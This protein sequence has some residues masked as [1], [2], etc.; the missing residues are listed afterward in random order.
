MKP[1]IS[2]ILGCA[3]VLV[4][5]SPA[6]AYTIGTGF[7]AGCHEQI[8]ANAFDEILMEFEG[9]LVPLPDDGEWKRI[10]EFLADSAGTDVEGLS[11][12]SL[13]ILHSILVGVRAPDT[14]GHSVLNLDSARA[15]HTDPAPMGQYA[16][17]L[18]ASSD[19]FAMGDAVA[20][21]GTRAA[22]VAEF[23]EFRRRMSS[24]E[25]IIEDVEIYFDFYGIVEVDVF[26]PAFHIGR[27][28]H[29]VQ[30]SFAHSIRDEA[31]GFRS[32]VSVLNYADAVTGTLQE[33]RDGIAHS[34][35]MD[36]CD[37]RTAPVVAACTVATAAL[38][39]AA[40]SPDADD[41]LR[42]LLD[43]WF[44]LR[45]PCDESNNYCDNQDWVDLAR[46]EPTGPL[47]CR[48][49]WHGE[50]PTPWQDVLMRGVFILVLLRTWRRVQLRRRRS[51]KAPA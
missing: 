48:A 11:D 14:E 5:V 39:D 29:T 47:L 46:S 17:A 16:H 23:D 28:A 32:I 30:D 19:D 38:F 45:E 49:G 25:T 50:G 18:R 41:A 2:T 26:A 8:T 7:T 20:A 36:S 43:E 10:A 31:D 9:M 34:T 22:L 6:S 37:E 27:A 21:A 12:R 40:R 35:A 15:I 51:N 3:A 33:D 13:F 44:Q 4:G 1:L 24:T 42:S